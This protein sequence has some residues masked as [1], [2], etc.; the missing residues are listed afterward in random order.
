MCTNEANPKAMTWDFM[1]ANSLLMK[2]CSLKF[3]L[4]KAKPFVHFGHRERKK[5]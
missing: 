4:L 3:H 2:W 1:C 5:I